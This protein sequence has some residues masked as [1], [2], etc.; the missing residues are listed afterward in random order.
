MIMSQL[1]IKLSGYLSIKTKE[2]IFHNKMSRDI[3]IQLYCWMYEES[4]EQYKVSVRFKSQ[5]F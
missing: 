3:D 5:F 1:R 4:V 2:R